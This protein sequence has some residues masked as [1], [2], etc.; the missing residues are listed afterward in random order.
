MV[1]TFCWFCIIL[2]L[3][4]N[5]TFAGKVITVLGLEFIRKLNRDTTITLAEKIGVT[6]PLVSQ[7]ESGKKPIPQKRISEIA[8]L[9]NVKPEYITKELTRLEELTLQKERLEREIDD[10]TIE[11]DTGVECG[12]AGAEEALSDIEE[13]IKE[14]KLIQGIRKFLNSNPIGE[15][16][17][18][19]SSI[20]I[21]HTHIQLVKVFL[22]LCNSKK[23]DHSFLMSVLRAVEKSE[24][25]TDEWGKSNPMETTPSFVD[26]L[27]K[28]MIDQ[29]IEQQKR[30]EQETKEFIDLFG[31]PDDSDS[32]D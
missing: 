26:K 9:Y 10:V 19:N 27:C 20:M 3:V 4:R 5:I 32:E 23:T 28:V 22:S 21:K 2:L 11:T 18:F 17:D 7:W 16:I 30:E 8:A 14:E 24:T 25:S 12:I 31:V 1:L 29:R 13:D 6:N 15:P